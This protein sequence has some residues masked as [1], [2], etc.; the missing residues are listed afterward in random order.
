MY[1]YIYIQ[2]ELQRLPEGAK[3]LGKVV[4]RLSQNRH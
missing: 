1:I 3:L 4:K 2:S